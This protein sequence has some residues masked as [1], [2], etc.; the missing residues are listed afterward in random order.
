MGKWKKMN[1]ETDDAPPSCPKYKR[2]AAAAE[3]LQILKDVPVVGYRDENG[4]LVLP[5]DEEKP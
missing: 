1:A 3:I 4:V 2:D 5:D